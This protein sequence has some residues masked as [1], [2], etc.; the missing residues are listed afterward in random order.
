MTALYFAVLAAG[1]PGGGEAACEPDLPR[2]PVS[3]RPPDA[4]EAGEFPRLQGR[5]ILSLAHQGRRRRR[6]LHRLGR[7]RRRADAVC[8]PGAGLREGP[9]LGQGPARGPHGRAASAMPRWTRATSSR[10]CSRAGS[11]AC[12]TRWWIIDYNRQSLD[13]VVREGLFERFEAIFRNLRLGRGDPE[14][15]RAACR[16]PSRSPAASALRDWI[17]ACPNQLYSALTFQ[18]GAAWRKR[19]L[20]DLGDQGPVTRLIEKRSDEELARADDQSRRP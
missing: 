11:T 3:A 4:R 10:R 2:H 14:V 7:P 17:D 19:L 1:G 18:G 20:D 16:R 15:R 12:A 9:W 8:Q 5:A 6:F 13:A